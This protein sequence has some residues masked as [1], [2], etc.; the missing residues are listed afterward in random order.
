MAFISQEEADAL[1]KLLN[2][3]SIEE[4]SYLLNSIISEGAI[5]VSERP[6]SE[7]ID[8]DTLAKMYEAFPWVHQVEIEVP[9]LDS[10]GNVRYV[11]ARRPIVVGKQYTFR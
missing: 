4:K 5:H 6:I 1:N 10:N 11:K 3:M 7:S 8:I 2:T 9:M